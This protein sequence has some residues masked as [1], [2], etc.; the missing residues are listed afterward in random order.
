MAEQQYTDWATTDIADIGN[1]DPNK[2]AIS[3]TLKTDGWGVVKPNL[4]DMNQILFLLSHYS[5]SN[6]EFALRATTYEAEAGEIV[7]M[8][9]AAAVATLNLPT[10]PLDGQ[11][12]IVSG[13]EKFSV[14]AVDVEGG[15][16]DIMEAADTN[17]ILD[18]DDTM[19]LF[20]WDDPNSLWKINKYGLQGRIL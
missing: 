12:V 13:F 15:T 9:N 17:C 19:F 14:F 7:V 10:S 18:I 11:W 4:Q 16:N 6:N 1:T 3:P 20:Y 5:R 2:Q 8:D